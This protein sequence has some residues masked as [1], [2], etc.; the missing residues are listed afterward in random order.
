MVT[1]SFKVL[2]KRQAVE[3]VTV[4]FKVLY[5]GQAVEMVTVS[6]RYCT[7]DRLWKW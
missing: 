7:R 1:V 4:S 3:M 2:Y 6:S 5:K